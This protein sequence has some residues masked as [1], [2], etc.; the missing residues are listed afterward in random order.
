MKK[1]VQA[2][3]KRQ[4]EL[5]KKRKEEEKK[6]QEEEQK[7]EEQNIEVEAAKKKRTEQVVSREAKLTKLVV[8]APVVSMQQV[9]QPAVK[10]RTSIEVAAPSIEA[11]A[12]LVSM[13]FTSAFILS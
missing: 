12:L 10:V 4:Q 11:V 9:V 5:E 8:V 2:E 13:I 1:K 6:K 7:K 3:Q